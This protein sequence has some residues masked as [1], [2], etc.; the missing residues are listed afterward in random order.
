ME[1]V[2]EVFVKHGRDY[3]SIPLRNF[4]NVTAKDL[5]QMTVGHFSSVLEGNWEDARL[6]YDCKSE[7]FRGRNGSQ[8]E[9]VRTRKRG[10]PRTKEIREVKH[11]KTSAF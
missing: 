3:E 6:L 2:C 9:P 1:W 8:P 5:E 10:R 11:G 7:L 4:A